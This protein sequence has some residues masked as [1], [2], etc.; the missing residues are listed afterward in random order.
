MQSI[1]YSL[2]EHCG[3]RRARRLPGDAD[4]RIVGRWQDNGG[5][6]SAGSARAR[7]HG[8]GAISSRLLGANRV[9]PP[10]IRC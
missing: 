9:A 3:R 6:R 10:T 1:A 4:R 2:D 5:A 7:R 8:S